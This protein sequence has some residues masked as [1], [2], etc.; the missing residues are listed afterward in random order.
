MCIRH[1]AHVSFV[2]LVTANRIRADD[3][4]DMKG[5]IDRA[6]QAAGGEKEVARLHALR[7]KTSV[8]TPVSGQVPIYSDDSAA[9][10]L[11]QYRAD[12]EIEENGKLQRAILVVNKDKGWFKARG[13]VVDAPKDYLEPRR[14]LFHAVRL[15]ELLLPLKEKTC[16]L[17]PLGEIQVAGKPAVGVRV[18][19]A[20]H[21]DLGIFFDKKT[22]LFVRSEARLKLAD[23]RELVLEILVG[24]YKDFGKLKHFTRVT[25]NIDAMTLFET[26]VSELQPLGE[27]DESAFGRP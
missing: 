12:L 6:V 4:A 27:L 25:V 1:L 26:H 18:S 24:D 7:W 2:L 21:V 23:G 20:G 10:G 11:D 17:S 13:K 14:T 8:T 5:L 9:L 22:G 15:P 19:R 3:A 16:C